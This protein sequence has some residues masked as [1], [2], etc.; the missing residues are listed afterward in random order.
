MHYYSRYE[1]EV[2]PLTIEQRGLYIEMFFHRFNKV[3]LRKRKRRYNYY[4][5]A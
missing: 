4:F 5:F 1:L 3:S 2:K